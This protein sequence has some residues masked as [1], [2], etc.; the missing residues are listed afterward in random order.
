MLIDY[1]EIVR[2]WAY[3]VPDGKPDLN[4]AYHKDKLIEVLQELNYPLDLLLGLEW[5]FAENQTVADLIKP[6]LFR[7]GVVV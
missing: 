5:S 6:L 7:L 4:N 3:R 2:E 1:D